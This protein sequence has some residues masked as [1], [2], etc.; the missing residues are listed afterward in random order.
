MLPTD[1]ILKEEYHVYITASLETPEINEHVPCSI[2]N[3]M[4]K[5]ENWQLKQKYAGR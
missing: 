3:Q 5:H 4:S 2:C 1:T